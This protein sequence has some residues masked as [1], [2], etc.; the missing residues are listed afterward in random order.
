MVN[1]REIIRLKSLNHS[2]VSVARS[3]GSSRNTVAEVWQLAQDKH[4][5][6]PI[7]DAL[8]N[9]DIE[10]LFY[11]GR[12]INKSRK[13]PDFEYIYNEL[14]KPGVTLSLLWA[15]YCEQ[16]TQEHTIPY[17]HTQFNEKY[18]AYAA[19]KKATLRIKRKPG[20]LMEV[21]W[22]GDTLTVFDQA[23]GE[24]IKAYV[25]V[26]CLPCSL[27]SYAEAFPDMK[28]NHWIE[29]H[30]HA[31]CFFEGVTRILVPDNLKTG[32]IKNTRIELVLNRSYHEMAE[33]YQ[34]AI[35]PARPVTPKDKPNA[36]GTVGVIET[37]IVAALRNRKFFS[38][39]ELNRAICEKLQEFNEKPFQKKKGSRLTAF[40]EEEKSFLMPLPAFSYETAIWSKA[41]IQPDYLITVG[42]CKY[43]VPYE[44]IGKEVELRTTQKS[45]E[46]FFHNNR[47]ASHVRRAY[48]PDP[49]YVP[50]HMPENHRKY[51][52]YNTDSFLEWGGNVGSFTLLV[53]KNF[54]YMHKVEQ[55]GYKSCAS[56]MKLADRYSMERLEKA[57]ERALSYT[58]SPS[59][60]NIST[61]LK[62]GQDKVAAG[63]LSEYSRASYTI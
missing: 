14:A 27:Y 8:T 56:L 1:Y 18:H 22:A 28:S 31:Y 63:T 51:L 45:I 10:Q 46:V 2:N 62:N 12:S 58:P 17:Q 41:T 15:E 23:S 33:Y 11:P 59:L 57:C 30:V 49:V 34:T 13:L 32:V 24:P 43:S 60:K 61:I 37:W 25:F 40:E 42:D 26:A 19:S 3:C 16:C 53:M 38:F 39:E 6:W 47:I 48:S 29:A 4:I 7:P 54:L 36:E 50:E 5:I 44:F 20:E 9:K 52:A 35:I 21:D 55:Q